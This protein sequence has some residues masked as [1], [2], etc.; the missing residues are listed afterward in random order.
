MDQRSESGPAP[1][2]YRLVIDGRID[3][4]WARWFEC[5]VLRSE[6]TR[7]VLEV[8]VIDQAQLHAVLRRLHDLHLPL[9]SVERVGRPH[10][11]SS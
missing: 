4:S 2:C 7:T 1:L 5:E 10:T 11:H 3:A 6:G 8:T 9:V